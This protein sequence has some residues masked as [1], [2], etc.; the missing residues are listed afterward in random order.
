[1]VRLQLLTWVQPGVGQITQNYFGL[2]DEIVLASAGGDLN[3]DGA[4]IDVF[5]NKI[6]ANVVQG[7][8]SCQPKCGIKKR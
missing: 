3:I 5:R 4:N 8:G 2:E 7:V 1:M 6:P